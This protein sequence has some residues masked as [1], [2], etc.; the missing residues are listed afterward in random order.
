MHQILVAGRR[1]YLLE[2]L[3]GAFAHRERS[4]V[5]DLDLGPADTGDADTLRPDHTS[6]FDY[7]DPLD[8]ALPLSDLKLPPDMTP[9][10]MTPPDMTPPD[11][12]QPCQGKVC[13][14]GCLIAKDRCRRLAPS[15]MDPRPFF[16]TVTASLAKAKVTIKINT[17]N[18]SILIG[19][20]VMWFR[21]SGRSLPGRDGQTSP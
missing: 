5:Q 3:D 4:W 15:N 9:P 19:K 21:A 16:D 11:M 10:D 7:A 6:P 13:S 8:E 17:D 18:G 12:K 1:Q 20:T 14:L 2:R